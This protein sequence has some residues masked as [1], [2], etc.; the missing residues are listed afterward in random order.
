VVVTHATP[1]EL[2]ERESAIVASPAGV[3]RVELVVRRPVE[4][5]R[6]VLDE[7]VLDP[8]VGL[9]GDDWLARWNRRNPGRP[10]DPEA[11]LTIM[12]SRVVETVAGD[13]DRWPLAGDQ[14]Y[15]DLDL[16]EDNLPAGTRLE[17]GT[18]VVEVSAKPHTGCQKF[19]ERFGIAALRWTKTERGRRLR[20]RGLNAKVIEGGVVRP[21]DT[22]T[23]L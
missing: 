22:I 20:L 13:R 14:L 10:P 9:T 4:G 18:A 6:E 5:E 21:G 11:Q 17:V 2:E 15:V 12:N 7:A 1:G 8:S 23:K 3:G 19:T 16:S